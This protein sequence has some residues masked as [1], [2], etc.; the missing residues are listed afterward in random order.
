ML[1][2]TTLHSF[3]P[4][5]KCLI[6]WGRPENQLTL[7]TTDTT[8]EFYNESGWFLVIKWISGG[9]DLDPAVEVSTG[10]CRLVCHITV[11]E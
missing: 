1:E 4:E 11:V 9:L 5:A 3:L 7:F 2:R 6:S 8:P 10:R